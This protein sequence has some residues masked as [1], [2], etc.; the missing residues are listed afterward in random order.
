M[1]GEGQGNEAK[2]CKS[3]KTWENKVLAFKYGRMI[4]EMILSKHLVC[5]D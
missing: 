2:S 3:S 5:L 1:C 4:S